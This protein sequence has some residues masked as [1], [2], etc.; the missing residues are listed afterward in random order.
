MYLL[1]HHF[2]VQDFEGIQMDALLKG[3]DG[4]AD[5]G[6]VGQT[7]VF[8]RRPR[9]RGGMTVPIGK[10]LQ[11]V[12]TSV[13]QRSKLILRGEREMF[14]GVVDILHPVVLRHYVAILAT[15][16]QQ[17]TARLI[18]C[19]LPGLADQFIYNNLWNLHSKQFV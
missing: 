4:I 11:T 1:I 12:L 19:V 16:T 18:R 7:E 2:A 15:N 6:V 3:E 8:L 10:N 9:G 13:L 5:G 17:V 14:R